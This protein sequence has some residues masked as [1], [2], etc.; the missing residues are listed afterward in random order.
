MLAI[1][2]LMM[3]DLNLSISKVAVASEGS[4]Q[5][6]KDKALSGSAISSGSLKNHRILLLVLNSSVVEKFVLALDNSSYSVEQT[7]SV[8]G[9]EEVLADVNGDGLP[10]YALVGAPTMSDGQ[11][12]ALKALAAKYSIPC[13]ITVPRSI[14]DELELKKK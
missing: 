7:G 13:V 10:V 1:T 11:K 3:K 5:W 2:R 14:L 9:T 4:M 12:T 6:S 8:E